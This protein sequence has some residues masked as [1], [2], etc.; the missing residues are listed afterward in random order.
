MAMDFKI[1]S[2]RWGTSNTIRRITL[3]IL[4]IGNLVVIFMTRFLCGTFSSCHFSV[5]YKMRKL[6]NSIRENKFHNNSDERVKIFVKL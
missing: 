3:L 5:Q 2:G 1:F 4:I 6:I